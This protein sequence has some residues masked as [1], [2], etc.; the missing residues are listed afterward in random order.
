[1]SKE[2]EEQFTSLIKMIDTKKLTNQI[3]KILATRNFTPKKIIDKCYFWL[4]NK[5]QP[6]AST[7]GY[8]VKNTIITLTIPF[9]L[10]FNDVTTVLMAA[11]QINSLFFELKNFKIKNLMF[12]NDKIEAT[13]IGPSIEPKESKILS[14]FKGKIFCFVILLMNK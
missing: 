11:N 6:L 12:K 9:S 7:M 10:L 5:L 3:V 1:M 4:D 8:L 2:D 14:V 13:K